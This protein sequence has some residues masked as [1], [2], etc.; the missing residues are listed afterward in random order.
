M[1][2]TNATV[3]FLLRRLSM[4][5]R[6]AGTVRTIMGLRGIWARSLWVNSC[7]REAAGAD[8]VAGMPTL[9]SLNLGRQAGDVPSGA[10]G[11]VVVASSVPLAEKFVCDSS[12][13]WALRDLTRS[14]RILLDRGRA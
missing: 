9:S 1:V 8:L 7:G 12:L 10:A 14:L 11:P 13:R 3:A 6:K 2:G 5:R 4:A